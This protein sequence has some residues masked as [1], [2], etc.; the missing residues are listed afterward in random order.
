MASFLLLQYDRGITREDMDKWTSEIETNPQ[1]SKEMANYARELT[2]LIHDFK[3]KGK[4]QFK[5][6]YG[7][8]IERCLHEKPYPRKPDLRV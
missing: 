8:V 4:E 3:P 5:A 7:V 2:K 6:V 1:V